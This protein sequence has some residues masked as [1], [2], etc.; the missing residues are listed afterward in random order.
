MQSCGTK[1]YGY[2]YDF[3][4]ETPLNKVKVYSTDSLNYILSNKK[5]Y[6][7]ID[8]NKDLKH[9]TFSKKGYRK[10]NLSTFSRQNKFTRE[11]PFGDT[12]YLISKN[13][14]YSRPKTTLPNKI[15]L[16]KTGFIQAVNGELYKVFVNAINTTENAI[17]PLS[18][19]FVTNG[20]PGR[21]RNW[22]LSRILFYNVGFLFYNDWKS[23][24]RNNP[25]FKNKGWY[26]ENNDVEEF[27]MTSAYEIGHEILLKYG[28]HKYSKGHKGSS[29]IITQ[30]SKNIPLPKQGEIDLMKYYDKYYDKQRTVASQKDVLSLL[31]LTK[32]ELR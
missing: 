3:D 9:L 31:W 26:F 16:I 23:L 11:L 17:A 19:K 27:K 28:G 10:F 15:P 20:S 24:N 12:I 6:F 21:S 22:E 18:T 30:K 13:S 1:Y 25:V 8:F 32:L 14:K 7:E 29:S 5:G 4:N 2:I